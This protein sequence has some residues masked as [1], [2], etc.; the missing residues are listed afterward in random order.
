M[1]SKAAN[2]CGLQGRDEV[3]LALRRRRS[4]RRSCAHESP[5]RDPLIRRASF[6]GNKPTLAQGRGLRG[7]KISGKIT[8]ARG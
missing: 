3:P 7:S 6:S 2:A 4:A 8:P 1:R 5:F